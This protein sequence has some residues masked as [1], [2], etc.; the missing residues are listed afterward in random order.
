MTNANNTTAIKCFNE[1]KYYVHS[2]RQAGTLKR[3]IL[4]ANKE[5][6]G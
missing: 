6:R 2:S 3:L 4:L 1:A 5:T